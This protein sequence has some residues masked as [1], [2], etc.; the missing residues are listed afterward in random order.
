[1]R[2]SPMEI[3][4]R[5]EALGGGPT[6]MWWSV[7][8]PADWK[9]LRD[10]SN[11]YITWAERDSKIIAMS[12]GLFQDGNPWIHA[13]ISDCWAMPTYE[14]LVELK[15][16]VFGDDRAA[17]MVL[18]DKDHHVN[19]HPRCLHLYGPLDGPMPLPDFSCGGV[20]I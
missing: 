1:M 5:V 6:P 15:S 11:E 18:P 20:S 8:L 3:A 12:C 19:I 14:D 13:S 7:N 2:T 16:V 17:V 4:M 9:V 10:V